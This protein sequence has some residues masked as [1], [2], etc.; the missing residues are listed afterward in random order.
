MIIQN[1][2]V[3][4]NS[5][6]ESINHNETHERLTAWNGNNRIQITNDDQNT[7]IQTN[8]ES[9]QSVLLDISRQGMNKFLESAKK[10]QINPKSTIMPL[11]DE[12][13]ALP[14]KLEMARQ[15]L[16][17]FFGI[18]VEIINP[19]NENQ[20]EQPKLQSAPNPESN[21]QQPQPNQPEPQ[22]WGIEYVHQEIH[23][24][25]EAV[26]FQAQGKVT[27]QDGRE[28]EFEAQMEMSKEIYEETT[29][30]FRA[31]DALIDPLAINLDGKGVQLTDEK[32]EFDLDNDGQKE[33]ISF[34]SQGSGFLVLDKN[35][36]GSVDNGSELF[37]PETNNGFLELTA[38]DEDQ[39]QWIDENDA[40]YYQLNLWTKN[41]DGQ[42]NLSSLQQNN[43]GAIYLGSANTQFDLGEGQLRE[44]GVYLKET[45]GTGFVQ[46]VDLKTE[47]ISQEA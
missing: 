12:E 40:I 24:E 8:A 15:L 21:Q 33:N 39:N 14:P 4:L 34:L 35:Q 7:E 28:I 16:E 3:Q 46:E 44:T 38:Y 2:N 17:K 26:H 36:N 42:D 30:E 18:K 9:N 6:Q 23:Y 25:K 37:G 19:Y 43:V 27:T 45:G 11:D 41:P 10:M 22:G 47:A 31:G 32:Y 5:Y 20:Q 1:H 29:V 13:G